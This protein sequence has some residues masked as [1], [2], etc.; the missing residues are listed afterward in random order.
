[1]NFTNVSVFDAGTMEEVAADAGDSAS[2]S[3]TSMA[4]LTTTVE[5]NDCKQY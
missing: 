4:N 2:G 5:N 3:G 1:M